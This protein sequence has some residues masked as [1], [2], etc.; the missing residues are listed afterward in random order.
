MDCAARRDKPM[1]IL[2]SDQKPAPAS[3]MNKHY[4]PKGLM[5]SRERIAIAPR[6][7]YFDTLAMAQ[8]P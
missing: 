1:R 4:R 8:Q 2:Q 3:D 5:D 6:V 7:L